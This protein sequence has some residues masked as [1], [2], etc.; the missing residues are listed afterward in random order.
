MA[1]NF[2]RKKL[3]SIQEIGQSQQETSV[4]LGHHQD[5]VTRKWHR[6]PVETEADWEAI[7]RR[8][9]LHAPGRYPEDFG[10]RL[11]RLKERDYVAGVRVNGPFWQI[12]PDGGSRSLTIGCE[13]EPTRNANPERG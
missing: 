12:E 6:F 10:Q 2:F 13:A 5:F 4:I 9:A 8:Y 1:N 11:R 3:A 7:K